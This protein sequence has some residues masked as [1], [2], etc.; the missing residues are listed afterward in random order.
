MFNERPELFNSW[1]LILAIQYFQVLS[2]S[3]K[4]EEHS[5]YQNEEDVTEPAIK[6]PR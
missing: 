6:K 4:R 2:P 1:Q 5:V 3:G